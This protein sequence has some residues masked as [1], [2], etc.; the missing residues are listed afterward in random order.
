MKRTARWLSAF[1]TIAACAGSFV[2]ACGAFDEATTT[3]GPDAATEAGAG[4]VDGAAPDGAS[5][6]ADGGGLD[7][8]ACANPT[9]R[10]SDSF[11]AAPVDPTWATEPGNGGSVYVG[12]SPDAGPGPTGSVLRVATIVPDGGSNN[13]YVR[14]IVD[15]SR[16]ASV[17]LSYVFLAGAKAIYAEIGCQLTLREKAAAAFTGNR[18][19]LFRQTNGELVLGESRTVANT[20]V[21]DSD[22]PV[23]L[24]VSNPARWRAVSMHAE[25]RATEVNVTAAFTD[26]AG[27]TTKTVSIGGVPLVGEIDALQLECGIYF[28]DD[29][30]G[31]YESAVDEVKLS[32]CPR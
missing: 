3:A 22:H 2:A 7:G 23:G 26:L 29:G 20:L 5:L 27:G 8:S 11:A 1:A 17:D 28:A 30:P 10:I 9:V 24:T 25:L 14:R 21:G 16:I 13:A 19:S 31:A 6:P 32:T 4:G 18:F 15:V 12:D